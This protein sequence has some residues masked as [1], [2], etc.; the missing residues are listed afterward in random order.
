MKRACSVILLVALTANCAA[1]GPSL[2]RTTAIVASPVAPQAGAVPDVWRQ[3]AQQL[4]VGSTVRVR[5]ASGERLT[6]T[7]LVTGNESI[8]VSPKTRVPEPIREIRFDTIQQLEV[9]TTKQGSSVARAVA[10]GAGVG[11][12]V[13][14]GLLLFALAAWG[15]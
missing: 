3:Y 1:R 6:A 12:G 8:S 13:F 2:T 9:V 14:F 15:D 5:T 11:A 10:V 4:R 7:L